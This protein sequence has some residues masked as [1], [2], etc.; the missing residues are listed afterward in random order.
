VRGAYLG[1]IRRVRIVSATPAGGGGN[2]VQFTAV[3]VTCMRDQR[4]VHMRMPS[5]KS[6]GDQAGVWVG[7]ADA[8]AFG[9]QNQ[10]PGVELRADLRKGAVDKD[11]LRLQ[12]RLD[13]V[14]TPLFHSWCPV[15]IQVRTN[16]QKYRETYRGYTPDRLIRNHRFI[17]IGLSLLLFLTLA[18]LAGRFPDFLSLSQCRTPFMTYC[19]RGS[20][21]SSLSRQ[22]SSTQL[23]A[24]QSTCTDATPKP[25]SR[26]FLRMTL[27]ALNLAHPAPQPPP[28]AFQNLLRPLVLIP[29][30][31]RV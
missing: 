16:A 8:N 7:K 4:T 10:Q 15:P 17:K 27:S 5:S 26:A 9:A 13:E 24:W 28:Q 11:M 6:K 29:A 22:A 20:T 21:P 25:P 3:A 18:W 1:P 31:D 14:K 19:T 2:K 23:L 30:L 12:A